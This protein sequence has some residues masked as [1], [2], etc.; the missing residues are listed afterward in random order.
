M[1]KLPRLI[2]GIEVPRLF[3]R[4]LPPLQHLPGL[5]VIPF[6]LIGLGFTRAKAGTVHHDLGHVPKAQV[7]LP[8]RLR[9]K[10]TRDAHFTKEHEQLRQQHVFP[11][12]AKPSVE[13]LVYF[14]QT[15]NAAAFG[16]HPNEIIRRTNPAGLEPTRIHGTVGGKVPFVQRQIAPDRSTAGRQAPTVRVRYHLQGFAGA[17]KP[18]VSC[19][20]HG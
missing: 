19:N 4:Y 9:R 8:L 11:V 17:Q 20:R 15:Q 10:Q 12:Q 5:E 6:I 14:V 2:H 13:T 3:R 18:P 1:G 16:H 7:D